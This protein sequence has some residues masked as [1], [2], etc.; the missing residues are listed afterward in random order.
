[1]R[2]QKTWLMSLILV[3]MITGYGGLC[4]K[5]D[6][7][8][9][10]VS[11]SSAPV[12]VKQD[13]TD[14]NG[15]AFFT[16]NSTGESVIIKSQDSDTLLPL[17]NITVTF[18]DGNGSKVFMLSDPSGTYL[19]SMG[20]YAHNSEHTIKMGAANN[21]TY[22]VARI[23]DEERGL[24][25]W[26]WEDK[27]HMKYADGIYEKTIN[28]DEVAQ[29]IGRT[30]FIIKVQWKAL[31][32]L[33]S[34]LSDI[35]PVKI[36]ETIAPEEPNP[37]KRW[38]IYTVQGTNTPPYITLIPSNIPEVSITS[39]TVDGADMSVSWQG[40]DGITYPDYPQFLP[41][42]GDITVALGPTG[43]PDLS[44]SYR[45]TNTS[46][47]NI[48]L[49]WT[50]W[51]LGQTSTSVSSIPTGDYRF[52]VKAKDEV[53]NISDI[54]SQTFSTDTTA[55]SVPTG[56]NASAVSSSQINLSWIGSTDNVGVTGYKIYRNG[57]YLTSI[58][59]TSYNDTG[60]SP[61]TT[62]NY[63]VA[64]YDATGNTSAQ[65]SQASDTTQADTTAPS[66]PTGLNASAV[67]ASQINLTWSASTDNVGVSGYKVYRNGSQVGTSPTT[68]YND[69][70]LSASTTYNYTVAA[71][72]ATGNT[73]AQSSQASATTQPVETVS[74]PNP[75]T[76]TTSG[77]ISTSYNYS[78]SGASSSQGHTVEYQ[79]DWKGDG[80]D[81]SAWGSTTQS[82]SWSSAGAYSV[83]A[84]ARCTTHTTIVSGWSSGLSVNI[85]P[86]SGSA[87]FNYT[88]G[89]Q[90]WVVPSGVTS[91]TVDVRGSQGGT[92]AATED[93]SGGI[94]GKGSRVQTN[95]NVTPGQ[96]LYI[97][98]GGAGGNWDDYN[99]NGTGGYNGG[100]NANSYS[101]GSGGGASDIRQG[102]TT[103]SNRVVVA[104]GG[105]GGGCG[106]SSSGGG[107][108]G[109]TGGQNGGIGGNGIGGNGG[110]GGTQTAGGSGGWGALGYAGNGSLGTGGAGA[111]GSFGEDGGGG[112][113]GYYGGGG[114]GGGGTGGAD[115]FGS[116]GGGGGG[117]SYSSGTGTTYTGGYQSGNGQ[118]I[119]TY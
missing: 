40:N 107:G 31:T 110:G 50:T 98:V 20:V 54:I 9:D 64:A 44:Y 119:I 41:G 47:G 78:T 2:T 7:N 95:L 77:S 85:S 49:D 48:Y 70:G 18:Y 114:G 79:F 102:G 75:P 103:L 34:S 80:T 90:T 26:S 42:G 35:D 109:G 51:T 19:P 63:T 94:G 104:G 1:M 3:I 55:P 29:M 11:G 113:G 57:T 93:S 61:S 69:T 106:F 5:N 16:D 36:I 71:Y 60:L 52:E 25:L 14:T 6:K 105:G 83:R 117:S 67:S 37:P 73:S 65:S 111:G 46:T 10:T 24:A 100:G 32:F 101:G 87:T 108:G 62:Y 33:F 15:E 13:S 28:Y 112:G 58:A 89:Q 59:S 39:L 43:N 68:S 92:G 53:E 96:T 91:I 30:K 76:G 82:K 12:L 66:V 22:Y 81:L 84:R 45:I 72:D 118:I 8:N 38:D 21:G 88:G 86:P 23:D 17:A 56:L 116:G 4:N 115:G 99:Y 74:P 27:Y 97:Y